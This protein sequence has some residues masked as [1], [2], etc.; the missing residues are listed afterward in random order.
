MNLLSLLTGLNL[1]VGWNKE[2]DACEFQ[3]GGETVDNAGVF[4]VFF[5]AIKP[6]QSATLRSMVYGDAF[7]H[8]VRSIT[9]KRNHKSRVYVPK[10]DFEFLPYSFSLSL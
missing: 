10:C 4:F 1:T 6:N 8:T 7:S 3:D 2:R 9:H 5:S